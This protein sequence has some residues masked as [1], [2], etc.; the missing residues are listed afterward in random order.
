MLGRVWPTLLRDAKKADMAIFV[1]LGLER[2]GQTA[3]DAPEDR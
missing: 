3:F 2:Y 1:G